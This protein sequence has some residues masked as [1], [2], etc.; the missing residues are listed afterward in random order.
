MNERP[1][2]G[3]RVTPGVVRVGG[4]VRRP[5]R[6][7]SQFVRALLTHLHER[8]FDAVPCHLGSDEQGREVFSF[9]EGHVPPDLDASFPDEVLASAARLIRRF[10]DATEGSALAAGEEVVCHNDLSPCNFVFLRGEPVGIID[11][12]NALQGRA[13]TIWATPSSSG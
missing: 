9:I 8:G 1:L 5:A 2:S 7:N 4:T 13:S 11:F 12:D 6:P 3:G 10:H